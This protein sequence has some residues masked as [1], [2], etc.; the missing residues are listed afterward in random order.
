MED[1]MKRFAKNCTLLLAAGFTFANA[2]GLPDLTIPQGVGINIHFVSGHTKDLD[3]I[4]AAG[5]KFIRMDFGWG[6]IEQKKGEYNWSEYEELTANLEKRGLRA[7]YILDYSNLLYEEPVASKNPLNG[8]EHRD[9]ASPQHPESIAA[10]AKWAGAA[11][12]RFSGRHII[13]EIWNEPNITFWKPKP[14][15]QQYNAMCLAA[16]KAIRAADASATVVAPATSRVDLQFLEAFCASGA[17]EYMDAVSVHPY[18]NYDQGP[19][20]A[21]NDYVKLRALIEKYAPV[22]KK[23]LPI[24]SG[25]WGYSTFSHGLSLDKQAAFVARQQLVD[26]LN[27][28]P[29]SIWYDWQNDGENPDEREEN[30]G[31]VSYDL[32]PK[33]AYVAL[34]ALTTQLNGFHIDHRL[35]TGRRSDYVILFKSKSGGG[36]EKLAAWTTTEPHDLAIDAGGATK[37][38]I[39]DSKGAT[40][41][42]FTKVEY[43][44]AQIHLGEAPIYIRFER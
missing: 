28:V 23:N 16:L 39:T 31:I 1:G 8:H 41:T 7:I 18:R 40:R 43:G 9:I 20:T 44:K 42:P 2:A 22:D 11:A 17:L 3:L 32:K 25:E 38:W 37:A 15:V 36:G 27:H 35:P 26:L 10:Y 14:D 24:I 6:G 34:R 19:E 4:S 29:I 21:A 5:I 30:F 13:W 12:K 33:P